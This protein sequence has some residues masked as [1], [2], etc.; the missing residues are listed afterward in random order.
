M[1]NTSESFKAALDG[2]NVPIL[3]LDNK[4]YCLMSRL[5]KTDSMSA[6]EEEIKE[7]LK[8]QGKL[9]TL[10][11]EIKKKKN[12]LL[13]EMVGNMDA[14]DARE[15]QEQ[16]KAQVEEYNAQMEA[17]QDELLDLPKLINEKN[18]LLM[19]ET[20]ALCY[21]ALHTNSE[22]IMQI[23]EWIDNIRIELKKNIVK[24]QESEL[25][26]QEMYAYMHD[27]FGPDVIDIFDMQYNPETEHNIKM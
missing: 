24:K 5:D 13:N 11:K 15:L 12:R 18:Y 2:K 19:L 4:W 23:S 7:L 16:G 14:E 1:A 20:M 9:N 10:C 27:I 3:P 6:L 25:K 17:Y 21:E 26:N 8:R 22:K